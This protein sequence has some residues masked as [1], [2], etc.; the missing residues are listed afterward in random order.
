MKFI[1]VLYICMASVCESVYEQVP[2]DTVEA[3]Q[4]ASEQ[5]KITAQEMFPLSS[6]QV[7]CLTEE[8][9]NKYQDYYDVTDET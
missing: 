4:K 2:Y 7:W 8:E 1:L 9:F 5:V 6:G 3:C